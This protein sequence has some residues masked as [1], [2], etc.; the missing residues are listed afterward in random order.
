M[1]SFPFSR[2]H[3]SSS[4]S[5]LALSPATLLMFTI[6]F[7]ML[8]D[9]RTF[10]SIGADAFEGHPLAFAGIVAALY[11]L[12][13]A[14]LSPFALPWI[15]KP[16]AIFIL[17]ISSVTS[18]YMDSLG[19][20][21]DREMIQNV[22]V[23]T[24]TETKH[25][26]TLGFITHVLVHGVLPALVVLR[27]KVKRY[28][29]LVTFGVPLAL[30]LVSFLL[31]I[32]LL[33]TDFKTY[34]SVL[35]GRKDF[36][37]SYQPG[38][39]VVGTVRYLAMVGKTINIAVKPIGEDATKGASFEGSSKPSLTILV[40]GET[41]RAQN[42]SLNGYGVQTNPQLSQLPILNFSSVSSCGT[43]TAVS[44]PCMFSKFNRADYSFEK[45]VSHQNVLD[46]MRHAGLAVE[47]WENNTGHKGVADR[48]T[49]RAFTVAP[50]AEFCGSGECDDGIFLH[51]L[52]KYAAEI[53]QDTVIVFHQIGS[54][55]P[56]YYIRYPV[57]LEK[58]Q[59][60]CHSPD[61][62]RCT[63][64]EI[65][66]AYDNTIA[67]TDKVLAETIA[68]L[69]TQNDLNTALLYVSD[70]GESLGEGGL[71]LHGTPYF[72]APDEQ[73]K[74]P[75]VLWMSDAFSD[76]FGHQ[77]DCL[78][79]KNAAVLSHDNL[80]HSLLGMLDIQTQEY[81]ASLDFFASC[82]LSEQAKLQ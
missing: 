28:S 74:V 50:E 57:E 67:Y 17:I 20:F 45:G 54:H 69:E 64:Q 62:K 4:L 36:M 42:F 21:I 47:W 73:T 10:W 44:L 31:T 71:Y 61:F 25:L 38:A 23:T 66:N 70:H 72:M 48:L 76:Q 81:D 46:V 59:P 52:K 78:A 22:M 32:G 33:L 16:F 43:S 15:A 27:I 2:L 6:L 65:V 51:A 79:D 24:I 82:Q 14:V 77:S 5:R 58:F 37:A 75:M 53:A 56:A 60:A 19:V 39:P 34:A 40:I 9:N 30:A 8:F 80:F 63:P 11:C 13:I 12:T 18:Y 1:V 41:A 26:I 29:K 35:R 7:V 3:Y 68:F 55:G 49:S